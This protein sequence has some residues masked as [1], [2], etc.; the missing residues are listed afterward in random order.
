MVATVTN[1]AQTSQPY[2]AI[3]PRM[4]VAIPYKPHPKQQL[5]LLLDCLEAFYGGAA[6][7]GKSAALL[8]AALQYVD[9]PT[10]SALILRR[11]F[12]QLS[13]EGGLMPMS[14]EWLRGQ[15]EWIAGK[16]QWVFPSGATVTFGHL[17]HDNDVYQYAGS[18]FQF[19]GFDELTTFSEWQY[20]FLFSRLVRGTG[21]SIPLRM[22]STSNPGGPG[23][24]WVRRYFM[25][26]GKFKN[27]LIVPALLWDNPGIDHEAYEQSLGKLDPI[28]RARL[29]QGD[30][31]INDGGAMFQRE[32]FELVAEAPVDCTWVRSWDLAATKV[33]GNNDPDWTAG[34][35]VGLKD[36]VWYIADMKRVRTTPQGVEAL[37]Q[38]TAELDGRNISIR[39]EQEPGASG[40]AIIDHYERRVLVGYDFKGIRATGDKAG[41]AAPV[42]SAAEAGNVR[43][44]RGNWVG[45]FLDEFDIFPQG[46]HDDQVDAVSS[47]VAELGRIGIPRIRWLA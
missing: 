38:Q 1:Q 23:H 33:R 26:E 14:Q 34:A 22:R 10:Y 47:A 13:Y 15:A 24:G 27:R 4:P 44:V 40:V 8:M 16:R 21:V 46:E 41:R 45:D 29:K 35:L 17:D 6:R 11:T 2:P 31:W 37:I 32:W 18:A 39:M 25:E 7:G 19:I 30:W 36:G 42:S 20:R 5:F 28:T 9:I 3:D 43:L 12:P